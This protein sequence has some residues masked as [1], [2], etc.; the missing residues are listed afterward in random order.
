MIFNPILIVF[1]VCVLI[2]VVYYIIFLSGFLRYKQPQRT[3]QPPIS[4][5]I[6]AH[7]E[8]ENL[9][10]LLPRLY[11][12]Q[13]SDFEIIVV[14]D[15]CNDNTYDLLLEETSREPRL[16]MVNV[17]HTPEKFNGKKYALTLGI[18]AAKHDIILLTDADCEPNNDQWVA[19]M[20]AAYEENTQ[21]NVGF[22]F[23]NKTKGFLNTFIRFETLFTAI[24]YLGL[25]LAGRP[26]MGV[27]RNLSYR[28]SMFISKKGFNPYLDVT[29][30]DDDLFVNQHAR[31]KTTKVTMG[32][33]ALVYSKPKTTWKTFFRQKIRHLSVGKHYKAGDKIILGLFSLTQILFWLILAILVSLRI[34]LYI[35]AGSFI[36]RTLMVYLTFNKACKTLGI[37][38]SIAGII[39]LDIFYVFYYIVTGTTALFT[40]RVRWS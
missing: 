22:S 30:G 36:L 23:Y 12:Q 8:E 15:R 10:Q 29:G 25:A 28:K 20:A 40:K 38:F 1:L 27:G 5:V 32:A 7:D 17:N 37:R 2:Q 18:K 33:D 3:H 4:I 34:E 16:K 11:N 9:K 21:F 39:F 13:Y 14:E 31:S 35:V 24:Q 6:A 19:T 26:Y